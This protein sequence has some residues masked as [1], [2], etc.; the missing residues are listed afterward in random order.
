MSTW[1]LVIDI[2]K[3]GFFL[4]VAVGVIA[5]IIW[6]VVRNMKWLFGSKEK[7]KELINWLIMGLEKGCG[8]KDLEKI[9]LSK[10]YKQETIDKA[11]IESYKIMIREVEG[12]N[13]KERR[14][15]GDPTEEIKKLAGKE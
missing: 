5:L 3:T 4:A 1:T 9:L 7:N 6:A 10:S 2:L 8:D 13:A 12:K 15:L 11:M 14:G